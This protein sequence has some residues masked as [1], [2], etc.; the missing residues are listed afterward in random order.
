M[1]KTTRRPFTILAVNP[2]STSTKVALFRNSTPFLETKLECSRRDLEGCRCA[3]DQVPLRTAQVAGFL[4]ASGLAV[5]DLDAIA[6]RGGPLKPVPGGVYRVNGLMLADALGDGFIEHVSKIACVVGHRL[7][8]AAGIPVFTVDPVSTDEFLPISRI[9]GLREVPRKSLVHAL[10]MKAMA[11]HF[12]E[13]SG[14]R[15]ENLN[16][17][18]VQLGGGC[19]VAVHRRGRM[20]D[21]VDA[22]GEGPFAPERAGVLRADDLVGFAIGSGRTGAELRRL[23]AGGG[24][25]V[26]HLGTADALEVEKRIA[27]GDAEAKR[28]YEA[29][30]YA[31]AK[32]VTGLA[33]AVNGKVDAVILT[34]GLARSAMLTGWIR[35]RVGFLAPV[36]VMPGEHEMQALAEGAL[37]VLR[38]E[39]R[40]RRYPEGILE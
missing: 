3:A 21:S 27:A 10:N 20:I 16:L 7:G 6:A 5:T 15:Y 36:K 18:T 40:P 34:G 17:I 24:G 28:V 31:T 13:R 32:A 2:G 9:S 22:N 26:S 38:G 1:A 37:R 25:L 8:A 23:L 11:R 29:M 19:S 4:K 30:A 12:A 14:R 39:E 33:A 35:R